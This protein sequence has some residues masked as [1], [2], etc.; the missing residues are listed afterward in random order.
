MS[1]WDT[2]FG[3]S[4]EANKGIQQGINTM[5]A[6]S[7][8]AVGML[9]PFADQGSKAFRQIGD[10]SGLSGSQAQTDAMARFRTD[11]GYEFKLQQGID[12]IDRSAASRG[13]LNSG[14]T[15]KALSEYGQGMADQSYGQYY[16][17]LAG[18]ADTG[19]NTVSNQAATKINAANNQAQGYTQIGAN[20]SN[21]SGR[22]GNFLG[23]ALGALF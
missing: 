8:D 7:N 12:A 3:S 23:S 11:P 20:R 4:K 17:R 1:L 14:Q 5:T 10:L 16:D 2:L 21:D 15:L 22:F 6:A 18:L 13:M 19:V 9:Q